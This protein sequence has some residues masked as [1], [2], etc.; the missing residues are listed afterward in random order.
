MAS[1]AYAYS[2]HPT[3]NPFRYAL[4]VWRLIRNDP[5]ESTAEA[6]IVEIGFA[7]SKIG[8]RFARWE[9]MLA[10]LREQP[11]PAEALRARRPASRIDLDS[12][13]GLPP[14]SLG[15]VFATHCRERNLDPNLIRVPEA[16]ETGW[17]LNHLYQTHDIWHVVTG[18][19][20][21]LANTRYQPG[22][23]AGLAAADLPALEFRDTDG[24][25]RG[26]IILN[27]RKEPVIWATTQYV[28][29]FGPLA[30][31]GNLW[32]PNWATTNNGLVRYEMVSLTGRNKRPE[33]DLFA[34]PEGI[35]D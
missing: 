23:R 29:V 10:A 8:R 33:L 11:G 5:A 25:A 16:D 24:V 1:T 34:P 35:A 32:V 28:Y 17:M 31:F 20:N 21:D 9:Q 18:W 12:L 22:D 30:R 26:W 3:R 4:A 6:A 7:R 15:Q 14:G 13:A 27:A 2:A 19:G